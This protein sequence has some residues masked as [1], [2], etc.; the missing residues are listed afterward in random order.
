MSVNGA[1]FAAV[2]GLSAE[3]QALGMIS[4][5]IS[6]S[7]TTAYKETSALFSTLV[8]QIP[9]ANNF[10][11]GGVVATPFSNVQQQGLL[12]GT[13]SNTDLAISG[14]G[15]LVVNSQSD[16]QG[17]GSFTRDGSFNVD[18]NGNL[19]NDGGVFLQGQKLTAAQSAAIA[20]GNVNQ[21]TATGLTELTTVNVS[22]LAGTARATQNITLA[23]N[24]PATD[25]SATAPH[26]ITVPVFDSQGA[27]HDLSLTLSRV[28]AQEN[29]TIT[30]GAAGPATGDA[31]TLTLNGQTFTTQPLA[32][33]N[34]TNTDV[35]NAI[36][37]ALQG[38]TFTASLTGTTITI[39]DTI[40]NPMSGADTIAESAGTGTETFSGATVSA[41]SP[42]QG[43]TWQV[44][45]SAAGGTLTP[46]VPG[47]NDRIV[48]NP[49]GTLSGATTF[50]SLTVASWSGSGAAGGQVLNLNLGTPGQSNG[51]TQLGSTFS[52]TQV[53]QDG[54][55]LGIFTGVSIDSAGVVTA[56]FDNGLKQAIYLIPVATFPAP[57]A[58]AP[59]SG[60]N[61]LETQ[62]SG[63][64]LLQQAGVGAAG[65]ISPSSLEESTVDIAQEFSNLIITQRAYEANAKM[66]TTA[67]QMLQTLIQAKQ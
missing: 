22:A 38:S 48:F 3:S 51:L 60:N 18:A 42:A 47:V 7:N 19:V 53:N 57:D 14:Q 34:P 11:P 10:Q 6:N 35:L 17:A 16:S 49:D 9:T 41:A 61:Y 25:T 67:D 56:N 66:I 23:A 4:N 31:F 58:L 5:N 36:N 55:T 32:Q 65:K 59:Q 64:F 33:V 29:F 62:A 43:N 24:L 2:S 40:G 8:T 50:K 52:V 63:N 37:S 15:F 13:S 20:N 46:L 12:Q 26:T 27:S 1:L 45:A 54:V 39:T 44:A 28:P 30:D 21:L